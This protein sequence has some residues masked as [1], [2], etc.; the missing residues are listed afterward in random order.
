MTNF[1]PIIRSC[2][3]CGCDLSIRSLS[4]PYAGCVR[5]NGMDVCHDCY[6]KVHNL[7]PITEFQYTPHLI[8]WPD[9]QED[10]AEIIADEEAVEKQPQDFEQLELL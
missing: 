6:V 4:D 5:E 7:E 1:I 8:V 3:V 9:V 2:G 10:E